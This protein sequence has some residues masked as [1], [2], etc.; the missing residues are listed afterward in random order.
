MAIQIKDFKEID[1]NLTVVDL[2]HQRSLTQPDTI[3]FTFLEDGETQQSTLT[4]Q[5][6]HRRSWAIASQ[7]QALNLNG[8]RALLLYPPGLDYLTAFFGCLYAGVVAVPAYPPRN[9]R[10]TPRISAITTDA[11]PSIAL[12]TT[13]MLPTLQSILAQQTNLE[14]LKW[15]TTD[16]IAPGLEDGWQQP[17]INPDTLAFLQYTS[18]STGTPKGV[19][20][21]HGNLLHNAAM[22]YQIMEHSPS[23]K[24]VSWLPVYHDMGLIGGIL[25]P[26]YGGFPCILMSPTAFL[27]RPYRWLQAISHYKGTTSGSPNFAYELCIQKITPEQKQTLDLSSWSVAFNGAEPIRQD[28]LERF[29]DAFAECGFRPEAFYPCY[30]MAEATLMISG[31]IKKV[32]PPCKTVVKSALSR[33]QVVEANTESE[34]IQS[35]VGCGQ[36]LPQQQ[37]AIAHPD[38]LT[39]CQPDEVGEIWVSGPSV[40][41]GY[42]HR[43]EETEQIFHAYLQDTASGPFL[44]TGD[45]GFLHNGELFITGRAKDLIIIR[46]RNLYPQDIELTTERSHSS[47][48][49]GSCA[50][51]AVEVAHEERLVVVQELE[52]RAKP[53]FE[54]VTATIRQAIAEVYDVQVYAVVL[55]KPGSIPKTSSGKIQRRATKANF[56]ANKLEVISQSILDSADDLEN[57]TNLSREAIMATAP[58]ARL[59]LLISYLQ[60]QIAQILKVAVSQVK[61]EQSLNTLGLDSLIVFDLKNRIQVDF[62]VTISIEDFFQ[63]V[64]VLLLAMQI[65]PQLTTTKPSEP[66]LQPIPRNQELPLCLSQERLWFLN[67]LEPHNPFYNVPIAVCLTGKL[68]RAILEQSLNEVVQRHEALRTS[69]SDVKG[70]PVQVITPNVKLTLPVWELPEATVDEALHVATELAQK[71]FD[72]SQPPLLR[73]QLLYLKPEEHIL[74]LTMHHIIA[75]GWS[76]GILI[77]ELAEV[78]QAISH[79]LPLTLPELPIQYADFAD[80]QRKWLQGGILHAQLDYWKQQ[81]SGNLSVLQLTTDR[82]R[83]TIQTFTGKKQFLAFPKALSEAVKELNQ[84]EGVTQFMTLIAVFKTLLYC[85][86]N[87]QEI[88]VGSPVA[89]RTRAETQGLIGFF[90]NTLVLRTNLS[91]NPSFRTL[92]A[93]VREVALG[94]YAHQELPFEKLVEELQPERDLSH[95]PLFQVMFILQNAPIPSIELP[96]LT[97]HPLEVDS[98]TSKFDLKFSI[99]ESIEGF[100]G[101]LEYKTELFDAITITRMIKDFEILL[102]NII[103]QP[104]I[105]LNELAEILII[106]DKEQQQIKEQELECTSLEKLKM[107]K[108]KSISIA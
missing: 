93:R 55:I 91:G 38:T 3:A 30:G 40:G 97:L 92:L 7:L 15:L 36:T 22:T 39:R 23:S 79:S 77:Q 24:F 66:P 74:L 108:R 48:R 78:Y 70:R 21:S 28:T 100:K 95:N 12:T 35:F 34:D 88:L 107:T 98:G 53:N 51:F 103:E 10:K 13:A 54:E 47:L 25:Q 44:R 4:Y 87:Q 65:L 69:F 9:Q 2:L 89:G 81:L 83:P 63:D 99:W 18:G 1:R 16:D 32:S 71:P 59:P 41:Q 52:F 42:W 11:Q 101:S 8:E 27:Q 90:I 84:R 94:A 49:L 85:Y 82:P 56:L 73:V 45:L 61:P 68:H 14:R 37:I 104:D 105:R 26:L 106:S 29:A 86:T 64:S 80:W 46:G 5:Q 96:E 31:G 75:D 43:Q 62:G 6:L 19:M 58:D 60:K 72:L 57:E 17:K 50:A 102:C 20:L 33:N 76:I 67:Q